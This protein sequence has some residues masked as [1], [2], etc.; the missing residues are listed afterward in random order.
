[1]HAG[2]QVPVVVV[3]PDS[4]VKTIRHSQLNNAVVGPIY[5]KT[6]VLSVRAVDF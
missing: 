4:E 6:G 2:L 5:Q 3:D 1:M